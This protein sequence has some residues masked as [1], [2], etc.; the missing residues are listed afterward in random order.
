M[1]ESAFMLY[2]VKVT[3]KFY[4]HLLKDRGIIIF[5]EL[6]YDVAMRIAVIADIHGNL[7]ALETVLNHTEKQSV[8]QIVVA[9]DVVI[10]LP[11]SLTCWEKVKGLEC[12]VIRGN[13]ERYLFDLDSPNSPESWKTER[14]APIHQAYQQFSKE[15]IREIRALPTYYRVDDLLVVHASYRN[16]VDAVRATSS[17]RELE[18]MFDGSSEPTIV[19]AHNHVWFNCNWNSRELYSIGSVGLPLNGDKEAQYGI[20]EKINGTWSLEKH[21]VPYDIQK[22]IKSFETTDYFDTA[23]P[24]G[25][26]FRQELI[27]AKHELTPF[28]RAYSS[29]VDN[30]EMTLEQ[31]VH[32][33]L[34]S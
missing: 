15:V 20:A 33:Y 28:W 12:L 9:G 32:H 16:D 2:S 3:A 31:A 26:L 34:N 6:S 25:K 19:R 29:L 11:H 18:E 4:I 5:A 14:Y 17:E 1:A 13:H 30:G 23:G 27:T 24:V 10:G 7:E 21:H 22:A 8:D